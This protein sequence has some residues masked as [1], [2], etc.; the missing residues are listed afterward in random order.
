MSRKWADGYQALREGAA[1]DIRQATYTLGGLAAARLIGSQRFADFRAVTGLADFAWELTWSGRLARQ[2]REA[3]RRACSVVIL[4]HGWDGSHAI[5]EDVPARLCVSNP[6]LVVLSPDVNGFGGSPF[7]AALPPPE[8][9]APSAVMRAVEMWVRLLS[10]PSASQTHHPRPLIFVGHSMGGAALFYLN[11][12]D[13]RPHEVARLAVA[14]A[15]LLNDVLRKGFYQ[16]LGVGIWAGAET[17]TLDWLK[18]LLAPALVSLLIGDASRA[19]QQEHLRIFKTTPKGVLAQTFYAMGASPRPVRRR[20]W[21]HFRVVLGHRDRLVGIGPMLA[22]L[23]ELG[24][25]SAD[26]RVMLGD[27]YLF[28]PGQRS[29]RLHGRNRDLLVQ[30][31]LELERECHQA[32][33]RAEQ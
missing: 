19:V 16:A 14:P 9:C 33:R 23:E 12:S 6:Y 25:T 11:E 26:L 18:E 4:I 3:L 24:F 7:I 13:W 21:S 1:P 5:W 2:P 30:Q 17:G 32:Q 28:S 31:V 22:L 8:M 27:H 15:L 10:L 29:R 20:T